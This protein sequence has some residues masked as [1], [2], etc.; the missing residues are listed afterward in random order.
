MPKIA[1]VTFDLDNTLWD[2]DG[3]IEAAE[4]EARAWFDARV[5]EVNQRFSRDD[6]MRMRS[7]AVAMDPSL[8]HDVTRLRLETFRRAIAGAGYGEPQSIALAEEG[9]DVFLHARHRVV[10]YDGALDLLADL[11]G[12]YRLASLTNGNADIA[13]LGLDRYFTFALSAGSVGASKPHPAM[14]EAALERT[15]R[16]AG[17]MVHIG[18]HPVDDIEGAASVGA[19]TVWVNLKRAPFTGAAAASAEVT[20]LAAIPDAIRVI[21]AR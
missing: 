7:E 3:V 12:R 5:P 18:D 6:F 17:E 9:F 21:E 20:S 13:R 14:F 11:K 8:A 10:F 4:R 19:H 15:G 1:L 16:K 2:V